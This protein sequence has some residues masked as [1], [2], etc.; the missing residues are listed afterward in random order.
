MNP[1][2]ASKTLDTYFKKAAECIKNCDEKGFESQVEKVKTVINSNFSNKNEVVSSSVECYANNPNF[3]KET[4]CKV[5]TPIARALI[6]GDQ[7][8]LNP[9]MPL[10]LLVGTIKSSFIQGERRP[11]IEES[12]QRRGS[13]TQLQN[14]IERSLSIEGSS[15]QNNWK[16][17]YTGY[18]INVADRRK[19][20]EQL[21]QAAKEDAAEKKNRVRGGIKPLIERG[22]D[23]FQGAAKHL[24]IKNEV[25]LKKLEQF[26]EKKFDKIM[27]S[28]QEGLDE[29]QRSDGEVKAM[30]EQ[31]PDLAAKAEAIYNLPQGMSLEKASALLFIYRA[32]RTMLEIGLE[33]WE[34]MYEKRSH[35][36]EFDY[37]EDR[38]YQEWNQTETLFNFYRLFY[39]NINDIKKLESGVLQEIAF[40]EIRDAAAFDRFQKEVSGQNYNESTFLDEM[41]KYW[42]NGPANKQEIEECPP[43]KK[44]GM[45]RLTPP[46]ISLE[47]IMDKIESK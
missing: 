14:R 40:L 13:I 9:N 5:L 28:V 25:G 23:F 34:N 46:N 26:A 36:L 43:F 24:E 15:K 29:K 18:G 8:K 3:D 11:S 44:V 20:I 17:E 39:D 37:T 19:T 10:Q 42:D 6:K 30:L 27:E 1:I 22:G 41:Q 32:Y 47:E 21:M 12:K 31:N 33:K 16:A 4:K 2:I 38:D 35:N 45:K 7:S